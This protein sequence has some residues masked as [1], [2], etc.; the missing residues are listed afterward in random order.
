MGQPQ[1]SARLKLCGRHPH[2]SPKHKRRTLLI[3]TAPVRKRL[4]LFRSLLDNRTHH[5]LRHRVLQ[6]PGVV[7]HEIGG[8]ADHV[9]LAVSIPP[10]VVIAD[11]IGELKGATSHYFN[12]ETCNRKVLGR[13]DGYGV[14]SFGTKDLPWVVAYIRNQKRRHADGQAHDRLERTDQGNRRSTESDC[15]RQ[16]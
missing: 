16:R 14:V 5:H 3:P 7:V 9:H 11:W 12:H 1:A 13:Q 15:C 8:T 10:T 2:P 4:R 6:T